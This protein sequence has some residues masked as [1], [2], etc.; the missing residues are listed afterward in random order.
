MQELAF[1]METRFS[2]LEIF[3][4]AVIDFILIA[5][6]LFLIIKAMNRMKKKEVAA[7]AATPEEL[8]FFGDPGC[9]KKK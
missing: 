6:V 5:F 7:P 3:I 1:T 4:A 8:F 9:T 2:Q